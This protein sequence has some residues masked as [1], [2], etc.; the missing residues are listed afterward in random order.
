MY[1][2]MKTQMIFLVLRIITKNPETEYRIVTVRNVAKWKE[3]DR[4]LFDAS[5]SAHMTNR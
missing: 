5:T 4:L 2:L 1:L 3:S